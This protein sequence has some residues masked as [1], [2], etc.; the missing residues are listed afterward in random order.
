MKLGHV[1]NPTTAV[2]DAFHTTWLFLQMA[3]PADGSSCRWL[4]LVT[5][6]D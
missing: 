5:G 6:L 2:K 3:L 1:M 4:F